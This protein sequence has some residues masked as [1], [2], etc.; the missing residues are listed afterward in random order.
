MQRRLSS[1]R[2]V[3]QSCVP[4][5]TE[6][7]LSMMRLFIFFFLAVII[8]CYLQAETPP[9]GIAIVRTQGPKMD[10]RFVPAPP[11]QVKFALL[12]ALPA[13]NGKVV[14]DK[15][16][17]IEA[18]TDLGLLQVEARQNSDAGVK[19]G[20]AGWGTPGKFKIDIR[21]ATQADVQGSLLHI[22]FHKH[23]AV[24]RKGREGYPQPLAEETACLVKL[25]STNDPAANP[26]GL[27]VKDAGP[28][29]PVVLPDATPLKVLLRD[30]LYSKQLEKDSEG[31][32]VPFEV[33]ED[34]VVDG[35][36][37]IRR[38]ALAKGHFTNVEKTKM[39]GR[40]AELG[41]AFD[42]VTAVDGQEIQVS[43]A[44]E[45]ARGGRHSDTM[46][47][48]AVG[49]FGFFMK[50]TDVFIRA[51]TAYDVEVSGQ[52]AVQTGH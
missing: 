7:G 33:A 8:P 6:Q 15:G 16:F 44:S 47:N 30:P 45:Q 49:V 51:G 17:H 48:L 37:L 46:S 22:E 40:H 38:G 36:I 42:T 34:V 28:P 10:E 20:Y 29:H 32:T 26:R 4:T 43:G 21:P 31:K 23:G 18:K 39:A 9:C 24:L 41:F 27:E 3:F 19:G 52:H 50:G 1:P 14:E 5:R 25:L 13:V 12:R 11:E 35:A 2:S